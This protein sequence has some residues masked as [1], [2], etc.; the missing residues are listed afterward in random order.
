MIHAVVRLWR[1]ES[2]S[3][4]TAALAKLRTSRSSSSAETSGRVVRGERAGGAR[5]ILVAVA[6][7]LAQ[8]RADVVSRDRA[9][10]Q[11]HGLAARYIDDRRFDADVASAAVDDEELR[12]EFVAHVRSRSRADMAEL[13]RRRRGDRAAADA[14]E[15][16]EQAA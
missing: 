15:F 1:G 8:D 10:A 4:S 11:E 5:R 14:R 7:R 3:A 9:G 6:W 16:L 12:T 13:V 2:R